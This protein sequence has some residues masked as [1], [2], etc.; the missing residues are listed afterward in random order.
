MARDHVV[1]ATCDAHAAFLGT[2]DVP[3][4]QS[5]IIPLATSRRVDV[6]DHCAG[7]PMWRTLEELIPWLTKVWEYGV[8]VETAKPKPQ[9]PPRA[10]T[11]ERPPPQPKALDAPKKDTS[12]KPEEEDTNLYVICPLGEGHRDGEPKQI[13]YSDRA[14]HSAEVHG[15]KPWDMRWVYPSNRV[16]YP[17]T[18][19]VECV[20]NGNKFK[21]AIS[22]VRHVAVA[23]LKLID[24]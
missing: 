15:C 5:K 24:Q 13:R 23:P 3:A 2:D 12:P 17:C 11:E 6:C 4:T 1:H 7:L 10:L 20:E 8:D 16:W 9:R 22:V 14:S 18:A 19:H 21:T